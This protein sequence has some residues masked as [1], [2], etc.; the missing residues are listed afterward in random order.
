MLSLLTR[1][2]AGADIAHCEM[3]GM[4]RQLKAASRAVSTWKE[5]DLDTIRSKTS[6]YK[7]LGTEE[8]G[9]GSE[10]SVLADHSSCT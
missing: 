8:D 10:I 7:C 1:A 2:A 9:R 4:G 3:K 5:V 6:F